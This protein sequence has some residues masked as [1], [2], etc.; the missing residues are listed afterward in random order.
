MNDA[1][2]IAALVTVCSGWRALA[3]ASAACYL[4]RR[5]PGICYSKMILGNRWS[6]QA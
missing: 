3:T 4:P 2:A 5:S 6:E 1:G